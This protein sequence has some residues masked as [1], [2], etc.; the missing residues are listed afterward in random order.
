MPWLEEFHH[1]GYQGFIRQGGITGMYQSKGGE[2]GSTCNNTVADGRAFKGGQLVFKERQMPPPP[3]SP[4]KWNPGY[5]MKCIGSVAY[6]VCT[7]M[8]TIIH[9]SSMFSHVIE[10]KNF[11][12]STTQYG[13][14]TVW[15][16][17]IKNVGQLLSPFSSPR[18]VLG[19][20]LDHFRIAAAVFALQRGELGEFMILQLPKPLSG[21]FRHLPSSPLLCLR[22]LAE[23]AILFTCVLFSA[24]PCPVRCRCLL[25]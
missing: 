1:M 13:I 14:P 12:K 25:T 5:S 3:H 17:C 9:S 16:V 24:F 22:A 6:T 2:H 21:V 15:A 19:I 18:N 4:P 11:C 23:S 20:Q 10:C 8:R 7:C